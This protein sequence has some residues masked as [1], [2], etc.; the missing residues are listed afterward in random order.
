MATLTERVD[1]REW[2]T[3][4]RR[5]V[6]L[7]YT[8]VGTDNDETARDYLL[9]NTSSTYDNLVRDECTLEPVTVDTVNA[10]GIWDCR[11]RYVQ[12]RFNVPEVGESL[13]SF[14][15]SGGSQ[16]ITQSLETIAK[17]PAGA[18]DTFGAIGD[19]GDHVEGVDVTV[20][21]Y[22]FSETHYIALATVNQAYKLTL[23]GLTGKVNTDVFRGFAAGEVLF[24][25]AHGS[26]RGSEDWEIT[27]HFAAS[28]NKTGLTVGKG[29]YEITGIAK[30]GWEYLWVRYKPAAGTA[31]SHSVPEAVYIER[32]YDEDNFTDEG[33]LGID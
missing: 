22:N 21:V 31:R 33:G 10:T 5:S 7:H 2:T 17:Y 32:V 9:A 23:F 13:F 15:T 29:A 20:P 12:P 18:D 8:L 24:L 16:H 25:G 11:V 28:K 4:P 1:S 27:F 3:G 19:T 26:Q 6:T 30:K 14:E